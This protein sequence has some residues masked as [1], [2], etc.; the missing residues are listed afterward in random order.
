MWF[1]RQLLSPFNYLFVEVGSGWLRSK[2]F[3]DIVAPTILGTILF[4][5]HWFLLGNPDFFGTTQFAERFSKFFELLAAFFIAAL[6]AVASME[7]K[8]LDQPL[9]GEPAQLSRW[10]NDAGRL[11]PKMVSRRQ[12]VCYL[13]AYL[14][15]IALLIVFALPFCEFFV[16]ACDEKCNACGYKLLWIVGRYCFF[17]LLANIFIVSL[18]GIYFL[19]DRIQDDSV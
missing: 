10:S 7:R 11:V 17:W 18:Y 8:F 19:S 13:F 3:I 4:F 2:R 6:A 15:A 12:F 14:S 16:S 1:L 9:R 5:I